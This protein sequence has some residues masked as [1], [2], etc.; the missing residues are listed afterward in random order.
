MLESGAPLVCPECGKPLGVVK[1]GRLSLLR[2]APWAAGALALLVA[3][4]FLAKPLWESPEPTK[5]ETPKVAETTPAPQPPPVYPAATVSAGASPVQPSTTPPTE[6]TPTDELPGQVTAPETIDVNPASE[7]NK[8]IKQEVLTR[9]DLMPTITEANKD[10][11]YNSVERA[12]TMGKLLT[13]P[14]ASGKT[15]LGAAEIQS[16]QQ[17]LENP[18]ITKLRDE[19]TSVFVILGYAD[20]KGDAKKNLA[21][22]Q[23]RADAVMNAMRDKAGVMNVMHAVGMGGSTLLDAEN[24]EKNRIAEVWVVLP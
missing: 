12:R 21:F 9:I 17:A 3:L 20:P 14:F 23:A 15:T 11:L 7:E 24:M 8:K 18:Q 13:V 6:D 2:L 4:A 10:K 16:L 19:L 1:G 5:P 22:S